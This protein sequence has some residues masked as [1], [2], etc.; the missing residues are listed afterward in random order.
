MITLAG[1]KRRKRRD[2]RAWTEEFNSESVL[3]PEA[4]AFALGLGVGVFSMVLLPQVR[5]KLTVLTEGATQ[6]MK[7]LVNRFG[8]M[9]QNLKEGLEDLVAEA[10]FEEMKKVIEQDIT[11]N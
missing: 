1:E 3:S 10:R 9:T 7:D 6:G 11:G 2:R 4:K 5:E 8:G